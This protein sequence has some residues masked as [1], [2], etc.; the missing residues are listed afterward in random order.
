M[1]VDGLSPT[2]TRQI[3]GHSTHE[4]Q[5]ETSFPKY[6]CVQKPVLNSILRKDE[7]F[8]VLESSH[9]FCAV[10]TSFGA[11]HVI[12]LDGDFIQS[13]PTR[14]SDDGSAV[15]TQINIVGELVVFANSLGG[16]V[17]WDWHGVRHIEISSPT[18]INIHSMAISNEFSWN[19]GH[20]F[21]SREPGVILSRSRDAFS[22]FVDTVV[23][24]D[25]QT[26]AE[27]DRLFHGLP[28]SAVSGT[29]D[30]SLHM[31]TKHD[32]VQSMH[33]DAGYLFFPFKEHV[34]AYQESRKRIIARFGEFPR[35]DPDSRDGNQRC[36]LGITIG[37]DWLIIYWGKLLL[38]CDRRNF[39]EHPFSVVHQFSARASIQ[40]VSLIGQQITLFID[41][42]I[43]TAA[44]EDFEDDVSLNVSI[45][46]HS[47][48][49]AREGSPTKRITSR[50]MYAERKVDVLGTEALILSEFLQLESSFELP[51]GVGRAICAK[52]SQ[53]QSLS[54]SAGT[55]Q[56]VTHCHILFPRSLFVLRTLTASEQI[57]WLVKKQRYP[58]AMHL[59]QT[60][61]Q[62]EQVFMEVAGLYANSLWR[63]GKHV[64]AVRVW[65]EVHLPSAPALYWKFFV[66]RLADAGKIDLAVK[67]LPF[68]DRTKV[69]HEIYERMLINT[70]D[71]G[72][73]LTLLARI[74]RW[75]ILYKIQP[76]LVRIFAILKVRTREAR[77]SIAYNSQ[78]R[79]VDADLPRNVHPHPNPRLASYV[80]LVTLFKL[81]EFG[82]RFLEASQVLVQLERLRMAGINSSI[83]DPNWCGDDESYT[84]AL[85]S[86]VTTI[87]KTRAPEYISAKRLWG[88]FIDT[89]MDAQIAPQVTMR[90]RGDSGSYLNSLQSMFVISKEELA[91]NLN[92]RRVIISTLIA[93]DS[94]HSFAAIIEYSKLNI[95]NELMMLIE[96]VTTPAQLIAFLK[97]CVDNEIV[98]KP[99]HQDI[100]EDAHEANALI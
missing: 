55:Q 59:C 9:I 6:R 96:G 66:D 98:L 38:L 26:T 90:R 36:S 7:S 83:I 89:E 92:A 73:Y 88:S 22:R 12:T 27:F 13:F 93:V 64:E 61:Y 87:E 86:A 80:L 45:M 8:T 21:Y 78:Q 82:N 75:P 37:G 62:R 23:W 100:L 97:L 39:E 49:T 81:Y 43:Q 50:S 56:S 41:T 48:H 19:S 25:H 32:S 67:W 15:I 72:D 60:K 18:G 16:I 1:K 14:P 35:Y 77:L 79:D 17:C 20:L 40:R 31:H 69:G 3:P 10:G 28:S 44:E 94:T 84:F 51:A 4:T 5:D 57:L 34:Y 85:E 24:E 54:S 91:T 2:R 33:C 76:V 30:A 11:V 58:L 52:Y 47:T 68:N 70:I 63:K 42:T 74:A 95:S 46:S 71:K 99:R 65:G 29:D 53:A